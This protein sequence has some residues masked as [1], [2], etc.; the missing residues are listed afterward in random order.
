[1]EVMG[2]YMINPKRNAI[3]FLVLS[4]SIS[5]SI[6]CGIMY[7]INNTE[8]YAHGGAREEIISDEEA[9]YAIDSQTLLQDLYLNKPNSYE[10]LPDG[11]LTLNSDTNLPPVSWTE[12]DWLFVAENFNQYVF[13]ESLKDWQYKS[14]AYG[15]DCD[16]I[17][18]G[19]QWAVFSFVKHV[20]FGEDKVRLEKT[21]LIYPHRNRIGWFETGYK[22]LYNHPTFTLNQIK[23]PLQTTQ[24]TAE[25]NGGEKFRASVDNNCKIIYEIDMMNDVDWKIRY[26]GTYNSEKGKYNQYIGIIQQETGS[27]E[28]VEP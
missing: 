25:E 21:L 4:V 20:S 17:V 27:Y 22:D 10:Y 12:A 26:Q 28:V 18:Y 2:I 1:V 11:K 8:Y 24:Q 19:S 3:F 9:V 7:F 5:L 14:I 16:E 23:I 15:L 6:C 13:N